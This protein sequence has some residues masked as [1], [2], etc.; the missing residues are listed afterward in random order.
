MSVSP[1]LIAAYRAALYEVEADGNAIVF[2]IDQRSCAL[3]ALLAVHHASC[4]VLITAYNPR[5]RLQS[6]A[7]NAA[8]QEELIGAVRQAGKSFVLSRACDAAGTG[9]TEPGL[10]VFDLSR[11]AGLLL[12]QRFN[13]NAIVWIAHGQPA[14][15]VIAR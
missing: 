11:D 13:Q 4:A 2:Q 7:Q 5:S 6:E 10:F 14:S 9:P 3:D 8:A 12:A 1:N 15:L